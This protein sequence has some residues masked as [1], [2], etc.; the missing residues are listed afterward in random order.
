MELHS[1]G[2]PTEE[3][4]FLVSGVQGI[5]GRNPLYPNC[6]RVD[7]STTWEGW[8]GLIFIVAAFLIAGIM[9]ALLPH[10]RDKARLS[11]ENN[12]A[13]TSN[14][15]ETLTAIRVIKANGAENRMMDK[16]RADSQGALDAAF[17]M[18]LFMSLLLLSTSVVAF[19]AV[20]RRVFYGNL[21]D[22][23]KSD[24]SGR[25]SCAGGLRRLEPW[26]I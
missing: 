8:F 1:N 20:I 24:A 9:R 5:D 15:Q 16:F 17:D 21:G 23:R 13:L 2:V 18:R 10:V 22:A 12:S 4:E 7:P 26:S 11:R 14:I 25:G 3:V 6:R 19:G